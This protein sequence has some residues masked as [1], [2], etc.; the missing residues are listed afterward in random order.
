MTDAL[1]TVATGAARQRFGMGWA[2]T[3]DQAVWAVA[4][5]AAWAHTID[6]LRIGE[7]VAL[8]FALTNA[9]LV[10][11]WPRLSTRGQVAIAVGFGLF[12]GLAA[13][14]YHL[15]PLI[16]GA[17]TWQNVSGLARIVAGAAMVALGIS[18]ALGYPSRG[19]GTSSR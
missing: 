6:E 10:A 17:V 19:P 16:D 15:V 2:V 18:I 12:W 7:L 4:T 11:M 3:R 5:L 1:G 14:P 9:A 8:P 13:I